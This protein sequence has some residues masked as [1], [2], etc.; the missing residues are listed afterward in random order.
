MLLNID[1][2]YRDISIYDVNKF[3]KIQLI[4]KKWRCIDY[5]YNEHY[6]TKGNV[7]K[8]KYLEK[9][10]DKYKHDYLNFILERSNILFYNFIVKITVYTIII[11]LYYSIV[12]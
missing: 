3:T 9:S 6:Y 7:E 2:I 1:S 4:D 5:Y 10:C 11:Y 8:Y 12:L